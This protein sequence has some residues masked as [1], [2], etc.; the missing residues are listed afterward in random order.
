MSAAPTVQYH[1][2]HKT[3][4]EGIAMLQGYG[5]V[6]DVPGDGSYGYHALMLL[7]QTMNIIDK[8]IFVGQ[9]RRNIYN[10]I[11]SNMAKFTCADGGTCV[12]EYTWGE[13]A[14]LLKK[15]RNPMVRRERFMMT[16]VMRGVW[17]RKTDF[18][19]FVSQIYWMDATYLLLVIT[20]MYKIARLV[21]YD[22]H[23][24]SDGTRYFTTLV[25]SYDPVSCCV[26]RD[27]RDGFI[28]DVHPSGSACIV[29]IDDR[30]HYM[31]FHYCDNDS[32]L[33]SSVVITNLG[34]QH[35]YIYMK[36]K[37]NT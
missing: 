10:H 13:S 22:N 34:I 25:Y 6:E 29:F 21:L 2:N 19:K 24:R 26:S 31:L 9:F 37:C 3:F 18:S 23:K 35:K 11:H 4:E 20:D 8:N 14:Q 15:A 7:L 16:E 30:S 32:E 28:H 5:H 17:D 12:Y 27:I 33:S 1:S 36:T